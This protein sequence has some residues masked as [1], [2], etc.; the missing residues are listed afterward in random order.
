MELEESDMKNRLKERE[1][2]QNQIKS[3]KEE[4]SSLVEQ[5]KVFEI[6]EAREVAHV[7]INRK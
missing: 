4:I 6:M 7:Q 2:Q 3:S 1:R 5:C